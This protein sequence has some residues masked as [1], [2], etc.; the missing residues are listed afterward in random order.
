MRDHFQEVLEKLQKDYLQPLSDHVDV[1]LA[2]RQQRLNA[3]LAL[4]LQL[5]D[6]ALQELEHVEEGMEAKYIDFR[7]NKSVSSVDHFFD[8][9]LV[10]RRI[11]IQQAAQSNAGEVSTSFRGLT[12]SGERVK[13]RIVLAGDPEVSVYSEV[14]IEISIN[15]VGYRGTGQRLSC[16]PRSGQFNF[17]FDFQF[18]AGP[19][20]QRPERSLLGAVHFSNSDAVRGNPPRRCPHGRSAAADSHKSAAS[21]CSAATT[22]RSQFERPLRRAQVGV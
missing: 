11:K 12:L 17:E 15:D 2:T 20:H 21:Q 6:A 3:D 16:V 7:V 19:D 22:T 9:D 14:S 5:I 13:Y 1:L 8:G 10:Y 4:E 18:A